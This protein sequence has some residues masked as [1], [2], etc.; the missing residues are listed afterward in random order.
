MT[1]A[2]ADHLKLEPRAT[3]LFEYALHLYLTLRQLIQ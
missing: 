1:N 3:N 2:Q